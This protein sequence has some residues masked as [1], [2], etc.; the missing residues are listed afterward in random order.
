M[1]RRSDHT[2]EELKKAILE[3]SWN[4]VQKDG[5]S[6]LTARHIASDIGY[7]PGT[8]Y[9]IFNSMDDLY[10]NINSMT[11]DKLYDTLS[12][13]KCQA[14]KKTPVQNMKKMA[15]LYREFT[16]EYK[17]YWLMLFTYI[18]PDNK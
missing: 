3:S 14:A 18:L 12:S 15:Q 8:I 16:K 13:P 17:P 4:I 1:A 5:F 7:A 11:L 10:L 6:E 2:R 9:N